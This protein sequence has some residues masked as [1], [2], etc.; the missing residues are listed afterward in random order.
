MSLEED[1]KKRFENFKEDEINT[2][3]P[4]FLESYKAYYNFEYGKNKTD[5]EAILMLI[6]HL[7]ITAKNSLNNQGANLM[8]S[9]QSVDGVSVSYVTPTSNNNDDFY[10]STIYGQTFLRLKKS[11]IGVYIAG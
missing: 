8:I 3:L 6:A 4:I 11:R 2:Y 7:I 1:F 10:Y 9:S 5:D